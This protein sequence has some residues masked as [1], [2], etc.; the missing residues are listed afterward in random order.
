MQQPIL[1]FLAENAFIVVCECEAAACGAVSSHCVTASCYLVL[2]TLA[3]VPL[4]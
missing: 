4:C 3:C 2:S 1:F